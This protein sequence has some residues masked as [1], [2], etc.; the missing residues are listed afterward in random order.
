ML[1][2]YETPRLILKILTP[3]YAGKVLDFYLKNQALFEKYETDRADNFYTLDYQKKILH[4][5][6]G[7]MLKQSN[8]RFYVFLKNCDEIIGTVSLYHIHPSFLRAEIG[9]KFSARY[10]HK[11]YAFEAIEKIIDIAFTDLKLQRIYAMIQPENAPSIKLIQNLG[12]VK[13]GLCKHHMFMHGKWVDHLQYC[14]PS[15]MTKQ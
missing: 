11:G 6:Y 8:I 5:E 4:T 14:L 9:Y 2:Q 13:E 3:N 10:H 12:F 15:P 1:L 7:L